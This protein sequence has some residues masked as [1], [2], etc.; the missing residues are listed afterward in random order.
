MANKLPFSLTP[1]DIR[2]IQQEKHTLNRT[3]GE[4]LT[5]A[6]AETIV[7]SYME[8]INM[9]ELEK[10]RRACDR[11]REG[12]ESMEE[13]TPI[14]LIQTL[15]IIAIQ[16]QEG[17]TTK[18]CDGN[19]SVSLFGITVTLSTLR[20]VLRDNKLQGME[21]K[22]AKTLAN[23]IH[24]ICEALEVPGNL[25]KKIKRINPE[26]VITPDDEYWLTDFQISNPRCPSHLRKLI[27]ESFKTKQQKLTKKKKNG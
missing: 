20:K 23:Q 1:E 13:P 2:M 7:S 22:L 10:Y 25:A 3:R 8:R 18:A 17:G 21:R 11:K 5:T 15:T 16:L 12:E 27:N 26:I 14:D 4:T 24:P 9:I 19:T 6:Q